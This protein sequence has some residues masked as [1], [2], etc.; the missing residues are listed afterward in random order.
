MGEGFFEHDS[1]DDE[2]ESSQT[3][4]ITLNLPVGETLL[5]NGNRQIPAIIT[6]TNKVERN[7]E[8]DARMLASILSCSVDQATMIKLSE[9][10]FAEYVAPMLDRSAERF[11]KTKSPIRKPVKGVKPELSDGHQG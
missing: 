10:L 1:F 8:R 6:I 5:I 4:Q 2:L 3:P 9:Y 7:P 11:A